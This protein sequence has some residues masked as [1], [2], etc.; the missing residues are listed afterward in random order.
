MAFIN[1]IVEPVLTIKL[2]SKGREKLSTGS[3]TYSYYAIGDSEI[4][5]NYIS[6]TG[7][8]GD[9]FSL[10]KP[11]DMNPDI[12]SFL[13]KNQN[14]TYYNDFPL[15]SDE[16]I[17]TN[18]QE[19]I[20]LFNITSG[21][22]VFNTGNT[23][24]KAYE[25]LTSAS[26]FNTNQLII[27]GDLSGVT[28]GDVLILKLINKSNTDTIGID[29]DISL[30]TPYL[31]YRIIGVNSQTLTLDRN[32]PIFTGLTSTNFGVIILDGN[33]NPYQFYSN[34]DNIDALF[35]NILS[36]EEDFPYWKLSV[37]F[38][39][40]VVG[41]KPTNKNY[42]QFKSAKY[43]GFVS[44]I[45]NQSIIHKKLGV[46][47]YTNSSP[48]NTYGESLFNSTPKLR[49]PTIMWHKSLTNKLGA[50]YISDSTEKY[51]SGT[52]TT[53][54]RYHDLID[55]SGYVVGKVFND[56]KLFVIEDQELLFAMSYKSNRSWSLPNY[57]VG[58]NEGFQ[59]CA[60]CDMTVVSGL[61]GSSR[62]TQ[63]STWGGTGKLSFA[64]EKIYGDGN[65]VIAEAFGN[66]GNI[67]RRLTGTTVSGTSN[68]IAF[69]MVLPADIYD[70][71]DVIDYG[72]PTCVKQLSGFTLIAATTTT[73]STT[74]PPTTT[75][76][77]TP[78]PAAMDVHL[79][80]V[81]NYNKGN[82]APYATQND[83]PY[84]SV[85]NLTVTP[86]PDYE[87]VNVTHTYPPYDVVSLPFFIFNDTSLT[88]N[89]RSTAVLGVFTSIAP[90]MTVLNDEFTY[91]NV[92]YQDINQDPNTNTTGIT[93][94]IKLNDLADK[95]NVISYYIQYAGDPEPIFG[96]GDYQYLGN[97]SETYG[98]YELTLIVPDAVHGTRIWYNVN[99]Q[100]LTSST[101]W[102]TRISSVS[103][104]TADYT[105]R[106]FTVQ[107]PL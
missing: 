19:S 8:G 32:L 20:G 7:L 16:I 25:L 70:H 97:G 10:L 22:T 12:I 71:V 11:V 107:M 48:L 87:F 88:I 81:N 86:M 14:I 5:Y 101:T 4:D 31:S 73:T 93:T 53:G 69:E 78:A 44:Y 96:T 56:L 84:G 24:I 1:K 26:S 89:Y 36:T 47:H 55:E 77:T 60:T 57:T 30:S 90:V 82:I 66:S 58:I 34:Q 15:S 33:T 72:L 27:E 95:D 102:Q 62:L 79:E 65:T 21:G 85:V 106:S 37:I 52:G 51:F 2:T 94:T 41:V 40:E 17:V 83:L 29:V 80:V 3:L 75:T 35:N 59:S 50:D 42:S 105:I 49:I 9:N 100:Y 38:T 98:G 68:T 61:T 13:K 76:T 54:M 23:C 28:S 104:G 103:S 6:K 18:E 45:Q 99:S 91:N 63:P 74:L 67:M 46:I 64:V 92:Y 43:A 39:N